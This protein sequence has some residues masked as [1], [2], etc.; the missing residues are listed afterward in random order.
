MNVS[1]N[2]PKFIISREPFKS[3]DTYDDTDNYELEDMYYAGMTFRYIRFII[4]DNRSN[5]AESSLSR[6]IAIGKLKFISKDGS[7]FEYPSNTTAQI[8]GGNIIEPNNPLRMISKNNKEYFSASNINFS[9][10]PLIIELDLRSQILDID[11]YSTWQWYNSPHSNSHNGY[12][13]KKFSIAFSNDRYHWYKC[14]EFNDITLSIPTR[15]L[16]KA[17]EN[18]LNPNKYN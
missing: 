17:Y 12:I 3:L 5:H 2:K 10:S 18:K 8:I 7:E 13:P 9:N 11:I 14:D 1:D 4:Y 6:R 16:A 15:N